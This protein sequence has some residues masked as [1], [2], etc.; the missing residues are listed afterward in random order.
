MASNSF[1]PNRDSSTAPETPAKFRLVVPLLARRG[2]AVVLEVSLVVAA[3]VVPLSL[4]QWANQR[5][6]ERVPLNPV[7]VQ[8]QEAIAKNLALPRSSQPI[9]VAPI[10]NLLWSG[11]IILPILVG[12][13]QLILLGVTG[14]TSPKRWFAVAVVQA[15]SSAPGIFRALLREG[16]GRWALP[17]AGAYGLWRYGGAFPDVTILFTL[18][19]LLVVVESATTLLSYRRNSPWRG[20][21]RSFHDQ[22]AATYVVDVVW[23][24]E[25]ETLTS[26]NNEA[27]DELANE[28]TKEIL[29][30]EVANKVAFKGATTTV[31]NQYPYQQPNQQAI[32]V[33]GNVV[34]EQAGSWTV[35]QKL[36]EELEDQD[37]NLDDLE[38]EITTIALPRTS[39]FS[40]WGLMR[41]YP[42]ATLLTA[43][44]GS[45]SLV[46][47]TFVATQVYIQGQTNQ[48]NLQQQQNEVFLSLVRQLNTAISLEE[49]QGA[50]LALGRIADDRVVPLLVDTLSREKTANSI[51]AIE[52]ALVANGL[53]S[54]PPLQK[55]NQSLQND[56]QTAIRR[57][58]KEEQDLV[59]LRQKA[60]VRSITKILAIYAK[61]P[62]KINLNK[63]DFSV[64]PAVLEGL[65]LA[66]AN[67]REGNLFNA[68][69]RYSNF[70]STGEDGI[71][72]TYDDSFV[73]FTKANLQ[74]VDFTGAI[75]IRA[76]MPESN[77]SWSAINK[78]NFSNSNL[79]VSNLSGAQIISSKFS[80]VNLEKSSLTGANLGESQFI[81][82]NLHQAN[83]VKARAVN[84]DFSSAR[85]TKTNWQEADA[86]Q[87]N[88][89]GA[90]LQGS[91]LSNARFVGAKFAN[92]SLQNVNFQSADLRFVDLRGAN[93]AGANFQGVVFFT[94]PSSS[95]DQFIRAIIP[96]ETSTIVKQVDFSQ[97]RNLDSKQLEYICTQ[98][99]IHPRCP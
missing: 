75:L 37:D 18:V 89:Q 41:R 25:E 39:P 64:I 14:Q 36:E 98:G 61:S 15:D 45:M 21:A 94:A 99:G 48:R 53:I 81:Q 4:G 47:G 84:T 93:L 16:G 79:A 40:L 3:A 35:E 11:A 23:L 44:L 32:Y 74:Q 2:A 82:A 17:L 77:L 30:N 69:L 67:F 58:Q 63:V 34:V 59:I 26:E 56:F 50:I 13:W 62:Q 60:V 52:Q 87:A 83:L 27:I 1:H 95:P 8:V 31:P 72:G 24:E 80:Q 65:D 78:A 55:L 85:L 10:T 76:V 19:G 88:F 57:A 96:R 70:S 7:L 20:G 54:L 68:S 66:G 5:L 38:A 92:A 51:E 97:V 90:N 33:D 86:S 43:L 71:Y 12:G 73:D 49:R 6:K 46:L 29:S 91:D 22:L 28:F 42:G 9:Q